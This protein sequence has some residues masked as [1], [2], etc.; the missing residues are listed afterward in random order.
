MKTYTRTGNLRAAAE[1]PI[2]A[3]LT[4]SAKQAD[5][6]ALSCRGARLDRF[7][8][9]PVLMTVHDPRRLPVGN[10]LDLDVESTRITGRLQ[11][12]SD[13]EAQTLERR[14]RER[15]IRALS[16]GFSPDPD[17]VDRDGNVSS[18]ELTEV[19]LVGVPMDAAALVY[20]RQYGS[21][22][23]PAGR[24][25]LDAFD[26][27]LPRRESQESRIRRIVADVLIEQASR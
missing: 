9:N 23:D 27:L 12:A 6:L 10:V 16:I 20:A 24:R 5:G 22:T 18:W 17:A 1:G 15:V 13:P 26:V 14:V 2:L 3:V 19:S 8:A 7:K 21:V 4:T 11:F 25:L